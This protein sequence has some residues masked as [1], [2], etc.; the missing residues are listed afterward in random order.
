MRTLMK[1]TIKAIRRGVK[2]ALAGP[3]PQSFQ[4]GGKTIVCSHCGGKKWVPYDL[5]N[6]ASEGLSR[7]HYGLECSVCS[8]LVLFT[9]KPIEIEAGL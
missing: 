8:Q 4:A 6:V 5:V 2:A 9:K 1:T 7:E 3:K